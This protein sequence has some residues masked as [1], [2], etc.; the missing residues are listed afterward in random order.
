MNRRKI[1]TQ[2]FLCF[3]MLMFLMVIGCSGGGDDAAPAPTAK[4]ISGVA[5]AGAPIIGT[6][7]IKDSGSPAIERVTTIAADGSYSID[8]SGMTAPFALRAD[9]YVG[10][11][12]YH[13]YSAAVSADINGTINITPFTDLIIANMAQQIAEEYY[14]SGAFSS[15]TAG[16]LAAAEAALKAKLQPILTA[17]GVADS[18]DLLR[19]SFNTDH[20]GL[21]AVIDVVKVTVDP[22][23]V[24]ATLTNVVNNESITVNISAG[25][26]SSDTLSGDGVTPAVVTDLQAITSMWTTFTSLFATSLP[27]AS[28]AT[29]LSLFADE[30]TFLNDGQDRASFLT[31]ITTNS[32]MIG[33]SFTNITL[34][35]MDE[36]AGKAT[37]VLTTMQNGQ[38][39]EGPGICNM[40]KQNGTWRWAGDGRILRTHAN[41]L[42]VYSHNSN[43]ISNGLSFGINS[44]N[45]KGVNVQSAVVTGPGLPAGGVILNKQDKRVQF[46]LLGGEYESLYVMTDDSTII[47]I[48]DTAEYTFNFYNGGNG[49]GTLL[50]T[51][52]E[53][54]RKRPLMNSELSKASFPVVISPTLAT[55]HAFTSGNLTVTWTLP[56]GLSSRGIELQL[57][58]AGYTES[59]SVASNLS[60][61]D[62]SITLIVNPLSFTV[63]NH[64][65]WLSADDIYGREFAC[66]M[67]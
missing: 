41:A 38:T 54:I 56:T 52:T 12:D 33:I 60:P 53:K 4:T 51:W 11:R 27:S 63:V 32:S 48:P 37:V 66:S 59:I 61:T 57:Y 40:I 62:I 44:N 16:E 47:T 15:M 14:T 43:T 2:V 8:V 3:L 46:A 35:S 34:L 36:A 5:A 28:N 25:G 1:S 13:L 20:T 30:A 55:L 23:T 7:T 39:D 22:A 18:I 42:A 19:T 50:A 64:S 24:K 9:G 6:V 10:G 17:L 26:T 31:D 65:L 45:G 29:L 67:L 58:D 49:T 21:D